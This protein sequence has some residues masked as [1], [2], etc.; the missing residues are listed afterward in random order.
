MGWEQ[1]DTGRR[2]Q[3]QSWSVFAELTL[4]LE[5]SLPRTHQY[6]RCGSGRKEAWMKAGDTGEPGVRWGLRFGGAG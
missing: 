5:T 4:G 6:P 1:E 3:A 2:S